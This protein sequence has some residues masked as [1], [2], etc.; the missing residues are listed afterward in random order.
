MDEIVAL[1]GLKA[2]T[3]AAMDSRYDLLLYTYRNSLL[4]EFRAPGYGFDF[5]EEEN[6]FYQNMSHLSGQEGREFSWQLSFPISFLRRL[7]FSSIWGLWVLLTKEGRD[8]YP[9]Y[10]FGSRWKAR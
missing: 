2:E 9:A 6:P 1:N 8:P 7:C 10:Q 3:I 4:H 5:P